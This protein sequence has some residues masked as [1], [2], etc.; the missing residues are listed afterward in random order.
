VI[1]LIFGEYLT[2]V[3]FHTA[4]PND[5][6]QLSIKLIAVTAV[7]VVTVICIATQRLGAHT[8]VVFTTIKVSIYHKR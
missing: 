4:S 8:A 5:I 7:L 3:L 1:S 2:R 6:S